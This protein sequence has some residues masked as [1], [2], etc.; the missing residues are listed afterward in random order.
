MAFNLNLGVAFGLN[1]GVAFGLNLGVEFELN[2]GVEYRSLLRGLA[3]RQAVQV[4]RSWGEV[5]QREINPCPSVAG[6]LSTRLQS[7]P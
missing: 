1:L 2:L 6:T 3:V 7:S 4:I 5:F